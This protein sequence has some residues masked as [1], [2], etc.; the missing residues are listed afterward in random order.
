MSRDILIRSGRL[1]D[2]ERGPTD[3]TALPVDATLIDELDW[4]A[5]AELAGGEG[6]L[7][8]ALEVVDEREAYQAG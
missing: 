2:I 8:K 4:L 6:L 7:I 1:T 5:M 3:I